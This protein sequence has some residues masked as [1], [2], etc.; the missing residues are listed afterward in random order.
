MPKRSEGN[1]GNNARSAAPN[2]RP[3]PVAFALLRIFVGMKFLQSGAAHWSWMGHT[4]LRDQ[5]LKCEYGGIPTAWRPYAP[6]LLHTV[7]PHYPL[8]ALMI[9]GGEF[10]AGALLV[11]GLTTRLGAFVGLILSVNFLMAYWNAGPAAQGYQ[12]ALSALLLAFLVIGAGRTLGV[13]AR[14]A[15]KRPRSPLW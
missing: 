12:E 5:I 6:F 15:R 13:D 3:A 4:G 7:L 9:V 1:K 8:F 14:L 10:L 2:A 11:L